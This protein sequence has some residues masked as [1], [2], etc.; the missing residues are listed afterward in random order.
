MIIYIS[1]KTN[2]KWI[3]INIGKKRFILL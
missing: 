3:K 2:I 1:L